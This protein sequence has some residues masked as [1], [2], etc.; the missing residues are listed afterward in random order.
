MTERSV[1]VCHGVIPSTGSRSRRAKMEVRVADHLGMCFGVRDAIEMALGLT[2][3]GPVTI[4]GDLV[5]NP[6]VVARMDAAGAVR[7]R[8]PGE[9]TT[10][11]VLLTAHGTA[12]RVKLRLREQGRQV[13]DA[14]CPLVTRVHQALAKLVAEGRHPVVIGQPGH[15]EVRGLVGDLDEYSVVI[16]EADG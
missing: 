6:E 4:L 1:F 8:D 12:N 7:A 10:E 2:R 14:A 15:V 13:P 5:H 11:T 16:D 3:Q 9:V